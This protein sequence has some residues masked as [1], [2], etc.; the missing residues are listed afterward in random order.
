MHY[1]KSKNCITKLDMPSAL[2][3]IAF[4]KVLLCDISAIEMWS[5]GMCDDATPSRLK[6]VSGFESA[7][8]QNVRDRLV[9]AGISLPL[10]TL[11]YEE[12]RHRC[13]DELHPH[14]WSEQLPPRSVCH[15]GGGIYVTTPEMCFL[16]QARVLNMLELIML[17]YELHGTYATIG[18][19]PGEGHEGY[20]F[21]RRPPISSPEALLRFLKDAGITRK[22]KTMRAAE[23]AV[24]LSR[25]PMETGTSMICCLPPRM[26]GYGLPRAKLNAEIKLPARAAKLAG[27]DTL[28][29]DLCWHDSEKGKTI[30]LEYK[31]KKDHSAE[32]H[33]TKD[34]ARENNLHHSGVAVYSMT[35]GQFA[36]VTGM[37]A[38]I[39]PI[40][41]ALGHRIRLNIRSPE[42]L[43]LHKM[44]C[45]KAHLR[46]YW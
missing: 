17:G 20:D 25:S 28:T 2:A 1:K 31:G 13:T 45:D 7:P 37:Y 34:A 42:H 6:S 32:L 30:A 14:R 38:V 39:K 5:R 35:K 12:T 15:V 24:A 44:M 22:S 18:C 21:Y 10:H 16:Q 33:R 19:R 11:T 43:A 8:S 26:G 40:A 36:S 9:R 27:Y 41:D 46:Q 4:M 29:P 23:Q 3:K